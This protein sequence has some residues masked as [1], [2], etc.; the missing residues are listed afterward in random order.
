MTKCKCTL[1]SLHFT[2]LA[3]NV[4]DPLSTSQTVRFVGLVQKLIRDYPTVNANSKNVQVCI[5]L[6]SQRKFE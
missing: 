5:V 6:S 4:W 1:M 2:D 3:E